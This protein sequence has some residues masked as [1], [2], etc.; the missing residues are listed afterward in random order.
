MNLNDNTQPSESLATRVGKCALIAFAGLAGFLGGAI[1]GAILGGIVGIGAGVAL[2]CLSLEYNPLLA[3]KAPVML[4]GSTLLLGVGGAIV[5]A[6]I[7]GIGG[8]IGGGCSTA[9]YL[10]P[11][12]RL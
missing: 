9:Q 6:G 10:Y 11:N 5:G 12:M 7:G 1:G 3:P 4:L 8:A 2:T